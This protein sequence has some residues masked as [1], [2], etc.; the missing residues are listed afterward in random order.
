METEPYRLHRYRREGEGDRL[1]LDGRR[2]F[3]G[4]GALPTVGRTGGA[5]GDMDNGLR[6]NDGFH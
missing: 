5:D 2:R 4:L 1:L 6:D 3:G